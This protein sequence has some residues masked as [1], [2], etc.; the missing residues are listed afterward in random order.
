MKDYYLFPRHFQKQGCEVFVHTT[1][2]QV[3]DFYMH[4]I[5]IFRT[6]H[7]NFGNKQREEEDEE[8]ERE[9]KKRKKTAVSLW[10]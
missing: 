2:K 6:W 7:E 5:R 4:C 10:A 9:K 1:H 8:E 3:L